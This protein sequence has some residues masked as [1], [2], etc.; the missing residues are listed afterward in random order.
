[1]SMTDPDSNNL[2]Q[3]TVQIT[4]GYQ[5]DANGQDVLAFTNEFG[6]TGSFDATSGTLTLSGTVY[7]GF[8]REA[9]RTVTYSSSGTNVINGN[10]ILTIIASDDGSP[11]PA[12]SLAVT[13]TVTV[14]TT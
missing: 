4:S 8:Y 6:I 7:V 1:V 10:R 2:T 13:R 11:N 5:N 14:S 3:L 9:L 12:F